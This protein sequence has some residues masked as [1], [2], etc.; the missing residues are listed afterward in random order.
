MDFEFREQPEGPKHFTFT[1]DHREFTRVQKGQ[2]NNY[3][4]FLIDSFT[5]QKIEMQDPF[6]IYISKFLACLNND[7]D[8]QKDE[9]AKGAANL[10]LMTCI[11]LGG[12]I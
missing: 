7:A 2:G 11:V 9:F 4:V 10:R 3:R 6:K 8:M 5:E 12:A 1:I